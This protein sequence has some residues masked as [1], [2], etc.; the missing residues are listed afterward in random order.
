MKS[1][2]RFLY[3]IIIAVILL[4]SASLLTAIFRSPDLYKLDDSP[5]NVAYNYILAMSRKDYEKA[6][7]LISPKLLG[8]PKDLI[9]FTNGIEGEYYLFNQLSDISSIRVD[10]VHKYPTSASVDLS[11]TISNG[12]GIFDYG[13]YNSNVSVKLLLVDGTW[14]IR[15]LDR[16]W[17]DCWN[18][19]FCVNK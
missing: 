4:V 11:V 9:E 1:H 5:E 8:Y 16:Y 14:R 15:S 6:Y 7:S 3:G 12:N 13:E 2:D 10:S 17:L 18:N 19:F